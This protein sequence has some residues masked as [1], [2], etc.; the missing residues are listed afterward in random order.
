[1]ETLQKCCIN[2]PGE[3]RNPR[4]SVPA[5]EKI[6]TS[7]VYHILLSAGQFQYVN[8]VVDAI[9]YYMIYY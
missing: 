4:Y 9:V 2:L 1:M 8:L 7:V 6:I 5:S 3:L